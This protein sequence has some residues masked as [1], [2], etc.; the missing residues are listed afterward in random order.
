MRNIWFKTIAIL[1]ALFKP[2]CIGFV[3]L[4]MGTHIGS[5]FGSFYQSPPLI[6]SGVFPFHFIYELDGIRYDIKDTV[7]Y[8]LRPQP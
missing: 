5:C 3:L 8:A 7:R 2:A 6:Q 4:W 1:K